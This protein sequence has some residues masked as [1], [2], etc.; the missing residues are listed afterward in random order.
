[1]ATLSDLRHFSAF[2]HI[3]LFSAQRLYGVHIID[4]RPT[5]LLTCLGPQSYTVGEMGFN[6]LGRINAGWEKGSQTPSF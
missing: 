3:I 5:D 1:M 4:S 6:K 2:L